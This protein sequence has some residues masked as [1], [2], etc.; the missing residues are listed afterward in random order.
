MGADLPLELGDRVRARAG[1]R[2]VRVDDDPL[3]PDRVAEGHQHGGELHRRAVGV[4]DDPLVAFEVVRVHLAHDERHVRVHSPRGRVVD[5]GRASS[6]R[7]RRECLRRVRAGAEQRDVD[8]LERVR[9]RLPDLDRAPVRRDR[10]T[11]R[12][13]GRQQP[14]LPDREGTLAEHAD[15]RPTD[16]AGGADDGNGQGGRLGH[17]GTAPGMAPQGIEIS[18]ARRGV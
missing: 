11:G 15:H 14:Q 4:G 2:L 1:H 7:L 8:A 5:H 6:G 13:A 18:R 10:S 3:D 16:D 9:R 12:P 17:P